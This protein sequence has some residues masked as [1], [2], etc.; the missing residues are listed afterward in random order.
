MSA[1][2]PR[3]A[4]DTWLRAQRAPVKRL[5]SRGLM[6]GAAQALAMCGAAWMV[7]HVLSSAIFRHAGLGSLWPY[8]VALLV[9][10]GM[11]LV[12]TLAQRRLTFEAGA[13]VSANVRERAEHELARRGPLWAKRQ[14]SGELITRVVD[15]VEALVPYYA[16]Y[17][18]QVGFA[19][20]VPA[21]IL[22]CVL[23]ADPWS[24]LI[25]FLTAP[26]I[27]LFMVLAGWAAQSAS[28]QRWLR[29]KRLGARFMDALSGLTT[30][31]LCRAAAREQAALEAAGEAYRRD[32]MAVL[33]VAF[34]SGLVLEFFATVSI[35]V[36]AVLIGFRLMWGDLDFQS[37][38]FVLLLA[39]EF[40]L[41][42]RSMGAQ[43][44]QRMDAAAAAEDLAK[45]LGEQAPTKASTT[46]LASSA[47]PDRASVAVAFERVSFAY[48]EGVPVLDELQLEVAAGRCLTLVGASGCGKSTALALLMGFAAPVAGEIRING[49]PL[50]EMDVDSWRQQVAWV[51]QRAH[52]FHGSLRDNLLLARADA[53]EQSLTAAV[54]AAGLSTV[55]ARLPRGLDTPL[56]EHG[57]GLSGGEVQRLALARAWLR[58]APL[59]LLD[60]PTQHLDSAT[61]AQIDDAL[62]RLMR[63][64]TVIR[65]AHRLHAIADTDIVAVMAHG[66]IIERGAAGV[67]RARGGA[68]ADL[69]ASDLAA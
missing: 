9:L 4:A 60:E 6:L 46:V 58:D 40:F 34:L 43:R 17:L 54:Q 38:L 39:P 44:H 20:M 62:H 45:L 5:L 13:Q 63:G 32:T 68:F 1:S 14:S 48:D 11:R 12:L 30:L 33:R 35:A 57:R 65:V 69:L 28:E 66:R 25:L 50:H 51:P 42:L 47:T 10:A 67:L 16:R 53:D 8:L 2:R 7:A 3:S 24:S 31:R 37:G 22:I 52:V 19:G 49:K 27:P 21:I 29:L 61:A 56:G 23:P 64:R 41:P 26:L 36:V 15:G 59:L 18:P 55:I